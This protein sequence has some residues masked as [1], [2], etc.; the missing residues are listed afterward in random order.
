MSL[1]F[2]F[3]I[4][5]ECHMHQEQYNK[6]LDRKF[7]TS[8]NNTLFEK[9]VILSGLLLSN[10][11]LDLTLTWRP[12]SGRLSIFRYWS[13]LSLVSF[14]YVETLSCPNSKVSEKIFHCMYLSQAITLKLR[15]G[16]HFFL[17]ACPT[18][19]SLLEL[20]L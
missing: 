18:N 2:H 7:E 11:L 12:P 8:S 1:S 3:N 16:S 17:L 4:F 14:S 10:I 20:T 19:T 5:L 9:Q 6:P 13:R 15:C